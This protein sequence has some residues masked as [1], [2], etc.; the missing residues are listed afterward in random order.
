MTFKEA[1]QKTPDVETAYRQGLQALKPGH[2][3]KIS[4]PTPQ[5]LTGSIDIDANTRNLYPED[6]RWDYAISYNNEVFFI[7]VHPATTTEVDIIIKKLE[8]LKQWLKQRAPQI[9]ALASTKSHP[10]YWIQSADCHISPQ[11]SQYKKAAQNKILPK[12]QWSYTQIISNS[13]K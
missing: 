3:L 12:K 9:Q 7:E 1:V 10:Y 4:V 11:T 13:S 2:A 5:N 8:W 6:P